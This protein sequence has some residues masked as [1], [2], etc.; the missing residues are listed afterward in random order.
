M[1]AGGAFKQL[2]VIYN[3][4]V[5]RFQYTFVARRLLP[6]DMAPGGPRPARVKPAGQTRRILTHLLSEE[7]LVGLYQT[8]LARTPPST[9]LDRGEALRQDSRPTGRV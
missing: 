1:I 3:A 7:L 8:V 5:R 4:P 9:L 2:W 6:L